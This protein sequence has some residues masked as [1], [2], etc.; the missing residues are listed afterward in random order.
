[1]S[2]GATN[3][4]ATE[5]AH[6]RS[7]GRPNQRHPAAARPIRSAG[8]RSPIPPP[9][10]ATATDLP[11]LDAAIADCF[12]CPRLVAWR[13]E[14][15]RDEGRPLPRRDLLGPTGAGLRRS[16]RA[17]ILIVGLAPAAHGG[18]RTGRVFTGDESGEFLWRALHAPGLS[19]RP[20]SRRAGDGLTLH[21]LRSP[22]RSVARRRPT[23][24]RP[25]SSD[26]CRPYLVRELQLLP[27]LRV[28]AAAGRDRLG[29]G[30]AEPGGARA[31]RCPSPSRASGTARR[32]R[33]PVHAARQLPPEP[34]EH[35]HRQA[36][37]ADARSDR[38]C[39]GVG[40]GEL[41]PASRARRLDASPRPR[42]GL[43]SRT[44]V[45]PW[46]R[47][48]ATTTRCSASSAA[49]TDAE[50]KRAF[51]KL[52]Q[53]WHP[54]VNKD[55]RGAGAVQGD[56]RG[57]PGPVTRSAGSATT[58]S[59]GRRRRWRGPGGFE[60]GL[61]RLLRTSST[62][63]SVARPAAPHGGGGRSRQR[64]PLRPPDHV[65]GGG[66]RH[67]EGDRVPGPRPVR[68]V[69]RQ[70]R[71]ARHPAGRVPAV[72]GSRRD[73]VRPPDDARPDGQR[74]APARAAAA[75]EDRRDAVRHVPRRGPHRAPPQ[76]RVS[77][78]AGIDEGHQI[79]LSNE[80]ETGP[81]GGAPGSLYVAVH[82]TAHPELT[83]EGTE[84]YYEADGD[85]RAGGARARRSASP[86]SRATR[87]RSRSSPA[88]SPGPR[89]ASAAGACRT[90][91]APRRAAT[92]TSSPTS[93]SR[94]SSPRS[95]ASCSRRSRRS[96]ATRSPSTRACAR[97]WASGERRPGERRSARGHRP[98]TGG[99]EPGR[100]A[101]ARGLGGPRGR[102]GGVRDPVARRPGGT[103]VEPGVRARRGGPRARVDPSGRR[104]FA[105]T[106]RS[107]TPRRRARPSPGRTS[108]LGHLQ[109]FG[110]RPI[111]DLE[112]AVVREADW[113]NAWKAHF[114]VLRIG[115]RIV[116][117]PTWRRHRAPAGRRRARA[118]SRGWPS[119]P[120]STRR[121]GCASRRSSRSRTGGAD[122][123][124]RRSARV[125]DVGCGS[126]ILAIAGGPLG[127]TRVLAVDVDP[128]AVEARRQ[129]PPQPARHA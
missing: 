125:L 21:G 47:R 126:G 49:P 89:S 44:L 95:S 17:R 9:R 10:P 29:R 3:D 20:V 120:G 110:L 13:E 78:P 106:C 88:R 35:V 75:R 19:D 113:A 31:T 25:W 58:C 94:R 48:N 118:R 119:G 76:L 127:A 12:A 85:D 68:H 41:A 60:A 62:P 45:V 24:R 84:L 93:S 115:R 80:G 38:T 87:P 15:A 71:Q 39:G 82:V 23:S 42:L 43:A 30:A 53:Q 51:R 46:P 112:P 7:A 111:G 22:P 96:R 92:S 18:N 86:R 69:R 123:R 50:I 56:Q 16:R 59:G 107:P 97:S 8:C 61:R 32:P 104:G 14:T 105:P 74:H 81:R 99:R 4:P 79:R 11:M 114:Q 6:E 40:A 66:P 101:G 102:R 52:A 36:H 108:E 34:A 64:P 128:I 116:I 129:R 98:R 55:A 26:A 37:P 83:R 117:R 63:S 73:P 100:V 121:R 103:S 5:T 2:G 28:I 90:C 122:R 65:R 67:R 70:R 91:V 72:Q 109:A 27:E 124:P 57:L 77:I 54:D 1:M 33:R